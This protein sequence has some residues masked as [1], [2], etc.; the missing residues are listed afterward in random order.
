MQKTQLILMASFALIAASA[1]AGLDYMT[2]IRAHGPDYGVVAYF[3]EIPAR[4]HI[5]DGV[6]VPPADAEARAT[7]DRD[8]VAAGLVVAPVATDQ[9]AKTFSCNSV[10]G[11]KRCKLGD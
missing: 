9:P 10:A 8:P 6:D 11:S 3:G 4:L 7:V 2:Q 5:S 1:V